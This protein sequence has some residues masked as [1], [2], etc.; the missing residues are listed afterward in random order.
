[1]RKRILIGLL[2]IALIVTGALIYVNKVILPTRVKSLII[3]KLQDF[4]GKSVSL[5]AVRIDLFKGLVLDGLTLYEGEDPLVSIDQLSS[6]LLIIP[7]FKKRI[8]SPAIKVRSAVIHLERR[9]DNTYNLADLF[10]GIP[11]PKEEAK[12]SFLAYKLLVADARVVFKD[13]TLSPAF[14][15]DLDKLQAVFYFSL[16]ASIKFRLK[17]QIPAEE[18]IKINA[19][20]EYDIAGAGLLA[21]LSIKGFS[22]KEFLAYSKGIAAWDPK[23]AVDLLADIRFKDGK[24]SAD[25]DLEAPQLDLNAQGFSLEL[26]TQ[27]RARLEFQLDSR[28]MGYSGTARVSD[29]IISGLESIGKISA[30][31]G[32][33]AFD[34][35]GVSSD[36]LSAVV[37]GLPVQARLKLKGLILR[38]DADTAFGLASAKQILEKNFKVSLPVGAEG[39]GKLSLLVERDF[40]SAKPLALSGSLGITN[41]RF[42]SAIA[43]AY[44]ES[45]NGR[46]DFTR[47]SLKWSDLDFKYAQVSYKSSGTLV[48][49]QDPKVKLALGSREL[50]LQSDFS[51]KDKFVKVSKCS[52]S[53]LNSKF[54]LVGNVDRS[55]FPGVKLDIAGILDVD[56]DDLKKVLK[57]HKER[58]EELKLKGKM[59]VEYSLL[60]RVDD[61]TS[62]AIRIRLISNSLSVFGLNPDNFELDYDQSEGLARIPLASLSLYDGIFQIRGR[63]NLAARELPFW[64]EVGMEGIKLEKLKLDTKS[65]KKDISGTVAGKTKLQGFFGHPDKLSGRGQLLITDGR[66]W[67]LDLFMGLGKLLFISDFSSVVFNE[68]SCSFVVKEKEVFID[69]V[70]FRSNLADLSGSGRIGFDGSLD[71]VL[72]VHVNDENAP[73]VGTFKDI[74]TAIVG[75]AGRFGTIKLSG[76]L[77][78]P[79]YKFK[80]AVVDLLK[81]LKD[82]IL[83]IHSPQ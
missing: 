5:D 59:R 30:V 27:A 42:K 46:V 6:Q 44:I 22:F 70:I 32:K 3:A 60:G 74:T 73:L 79:K 71:G 19:S 68:G 10:T 33:F 50:K 43:D 81:G 47:N 9:Q 49:F 57:K 21:K 13:N 55:S 35:T 11:A 54:S 12:F 75:Q 72:S 82:A 64:V 4:T 58:L 65:K 7:I 8:I 14:T 69:D 25:V 76:T 62:A 37:L 16:P 78:E 63:M 67:Q 17:F 1:M 23:G 80:A 40:L 28:K 2:I 51:V 61:L 38:I 34:N 29:S 77:K 24:L 15:R 48:D 31:S 36:D 45:V 53:F 52:G 26:H 20:G 41:A 39:E 56:L 66:L 18:P 83:G